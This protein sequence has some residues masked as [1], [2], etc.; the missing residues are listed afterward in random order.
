MSERWADA[1]IPDGQALLNLVYAESDRQVAKWGHQVHSPAEWSLILAE[2]WGELGQ[3][4]CVAHF[5]GKVSPNLGREAVQVAT[6][7]LKIYVMAEARRALAA[8]KEAEP[9]AS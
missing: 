2:E 5:Y 1:G 9:R 8:S 6:L 4:L 7:A 3:E